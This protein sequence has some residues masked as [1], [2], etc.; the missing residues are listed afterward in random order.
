MSLVRLAPVFSTTAGGLSRRKATLA[1]WHAAD[2]HKGPEDRPHPRGSQSARKD[3][4]AHSRHMS[5]MRN[6]ACTRASKLY[7]SGSLY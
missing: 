1:R 6:Q 3:P 7:K 4:K 2:F 5:A